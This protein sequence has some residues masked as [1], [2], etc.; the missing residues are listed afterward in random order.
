MARKVIWSDD[1]IADLAA[2]VSHIAEDN[3]R[4]AERTGRAILE[5]ARMLEIFPQA[6]RILPEDGR[7]SV[8]EIQYPPWRI[9]YE[10]PDNDLVIILRIWHAARGQPE[11]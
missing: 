6:G 1:A 5:Q 10:L 11:V 7:P 9:I 8:R 3:R 2:L 4:A